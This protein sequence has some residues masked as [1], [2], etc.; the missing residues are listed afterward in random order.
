MPSFCTL[1]SWRWSSSSGLDGG[2]PRVRVVAD[3]VYGS[4]SN[5]RRVLEARDQAYVAGTNQ[6]VSTWPFYGPPGPWIVVASVVSGALTA[7]VVTWTRR[8]C[9]DGIQ[10]LAPGDWVYLPVRPAPV[11]AG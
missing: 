9:G 7:G 2:S 5:F 11:T 1:S 6:P 8:S 4:D 10:V 3:E